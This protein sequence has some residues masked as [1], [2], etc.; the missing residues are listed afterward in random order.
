MNENYTVYMHR[1]PN[2]KVYI[3]ITSKKP[4]LRW[5]SGKGYQTQNV[6]KAILKYGWENI[7]H[8]ILLSGLSKEDA[9]KKEIEFIS[10]FRANEREFGYNIESGGSCSRPLSEQTKQKIRIA[11]IGTKASEETKKKMSEARK[12]KPGKRMLGKDNPN[13][14]NHKIAGENN[15][16]Y[17]KR[18]TKET[19]EFLRQ[20]ATGVVFSEET[21]KRLS[22]SHKGLLVG[23]KNPMYGVT[24]SKNKN[25]KKIVQYTKEGV[26]VKVW[27][28]AADV[29]RETGIAHNSIGRCCNGNL[30]SAGGFVWRHYN[31]NQP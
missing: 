2:G 4:E 12:G 14:G 13:Y 11:R 16:F 15:P 10:A 8:I 23:E 19:I 29:E 6:Y 18:H 31:A 20:K 27:D 1:F 7:E 3:G 24:G 30:R 17:G 25:S 22:E 26:F 5:M 21:R 9:E 28:C